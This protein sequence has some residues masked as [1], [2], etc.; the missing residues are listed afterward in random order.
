MEAAGQTFWGKFFHPLS[1]MKNR[2]KA[3]W[4]DIQTFGKEYNNA[5]N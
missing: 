2:M 1:E 5:K 3:E 4:N